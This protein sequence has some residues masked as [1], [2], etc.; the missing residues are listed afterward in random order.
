[1]KDCLAFI[2]LLLAGCGLAPEHSPALP[3]ADTVAL[4]QAHGYQLGMSTDQ[5]R[6]A[7][8]VRGDSL[9]CVIRE[10]YLLCHPGE[11][12]RRGLE[13]Y[14]LM[15][16]AGR[17]HLIA[18]ESDLPLAELCSRYAGL[19]TLAAMGPGSDA[20]PEDTLA[21]WISADSTVSRTAVCVQVRGFAPCSMSAQRS[22]P[23]E[24]R[25]R[26]LL[27]RQ[28]FAKRQARQAETPPR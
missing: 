19:G 4:G 28:E 24:L 17:L 25:S 2:V 23:A 20:L 11:A 18:W 13:S 1:M 7:A 10:E 5:A 22:N 9:T 26:I 6:R 16:R 21:L 15:F 14:G 12:A 3:M 8:A 27:L